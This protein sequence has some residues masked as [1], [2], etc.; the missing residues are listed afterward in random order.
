[1]SLGYLRGMMNQLDQI[2]RL[3]PE[4]A[5]WA[6]KQRAMARQFQLDALARSL[7]ELEK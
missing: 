6:D 1:M 3:Q 5:P 2:E 7:A 4:C